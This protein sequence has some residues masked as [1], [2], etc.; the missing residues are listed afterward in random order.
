MTGKG[1][2]RWGQAGGD[3]GRSVRA[4]MQVF[5]PKFLA[6]IRANFV[7]TYEKVRLNSYSD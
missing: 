1:K 5:L 6:N 7:P 3:D 2:G 4:C